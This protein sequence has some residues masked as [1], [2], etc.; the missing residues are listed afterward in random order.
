M[1]IHED[2][3][4]ELPVIE[5]IIRWHDKAIND[6][7][8]INTRK[9]DEIRSDILLGNKEAYFL[10]VKDDEQK[11]IIPIDTGHLELYVEWE[12]LTDSYKAKVNRK[13]KTRFIDN[14]SISYDK[15]Y[16]IE[17]TCKFFFID[18]K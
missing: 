6:F 14:H 10:K 8:S 7:N 12:A 17:A 9:F 4:G 2:I 5:V 3:F 18:I 13:K 16:F 15:N 1:A 11:I